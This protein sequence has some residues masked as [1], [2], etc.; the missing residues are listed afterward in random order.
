MESC[1]G[2]ERFLTGPST[3]K[4]RFV[5]LSSPDS[6]IIVL[7]LL[8]FAI[9]AIAWV[10]MLVRNLPLS[11]PIFC[12]AAGFLVFTWHEGGEKPLPLRFPEI[13]E[14]LSELIVI[15]AL[16]GAGLKIDRPVGW[17]S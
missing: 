16:M 10:P 1:S 17:R 7:I 3:A 9:L 8:G 14:R 12:V 15:I 2:L 11:L 5:L 4:S 6:Y 13:S